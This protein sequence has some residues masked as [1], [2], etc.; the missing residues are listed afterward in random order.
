MRKITITWVKLISQC[1]WLVEIG[2]LGFEFRSFDFK[3]FLKVILNPSVIQRDNLHFV[4]ENQESERVGNH[5]ECE[6]EEGLTPEKKRTW[7]SALHM[8]GL[9]KKSYWIA[10]SIHFRINT[11]LWFILR[12]H[13]WFLYTKFLWSVPSPAS[14]SGF[15]S[16]ASQS[17]IISI[18]WELVRNTNYWAPPRP[19]QSKILKVETGKLCFNSFF[20]SAKFEIHW[21]EAYILSTPPTGFPL[22]YRA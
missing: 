7:N 16:V 14:G 10:K 13:I 20:G 12:G 21:S 2:N 5:W 1:S 18:T 22:T 8:A 11:V 3:A 4:S 9:R 15:Q 17:S 6:G 19:I